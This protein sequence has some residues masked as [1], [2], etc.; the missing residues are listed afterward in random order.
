MVA[1]GPVDEVW[2]AM[3]VGAPIAAGLP[4]T[5]MR[6]ASHRHPFVSTRDVAAYC[7][8]VI[9]RPEAVNQRVAVGGPL[10]MTW[11]EVVGVYERV[12]GRPVDTYFV[13]FGE[14]L[15]GA[16]EFVSAMMSGMESA[17]IDIDMSATSLAY[18]IT[19]TPLESAVAAMA[20]A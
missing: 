17:D 5:L 8:A 3:I 19:P 16:P 20:V 14:P 6:P 15:P 10:S 9:G 18:G 11:P 2:P 7:T 4:V 12:T 1:P 13:D